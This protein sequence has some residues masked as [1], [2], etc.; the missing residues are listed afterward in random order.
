MFS[1]Q[2]TTG[3]VGGVERRGLDELSADR[4]REIGRTF[5]YPVGAWTCMG[6]R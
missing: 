4:T 5:R 3:H 2:C 1:P 6:H